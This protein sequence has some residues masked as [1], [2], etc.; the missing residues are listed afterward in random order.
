MGAAEGCV[1]QPSL[2]F[3]STPAP[4]AGTITISLVQVREGGWS[5]DSQPE[6]GCAGKAGKALLPPGV[7]QAMGLREDLALGR[8]RP[9]GED[10]AHSEWSSDH[11]SEILWQHSY[12]PD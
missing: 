10:W 7:R 12:D 5:W 2:L 4:Q 3:L 11:Q 9:G 6:L 8:C 1:S